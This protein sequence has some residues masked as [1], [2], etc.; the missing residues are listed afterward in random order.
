MKRLALI[1]ATL[2]LIVPAAAIE[3]CAQGKRSH[4]VVDG[5]TFWWRGE[6]IRIEAID[7]PELGQPL[8]AGERS[9]AVL[10]RDGLLSLLQQ[11]EVRISRHGP[12]RYD[13]T[14]ATVSVGGKDVGHELIA[15]G[16]AQPWLGRKATWCP[17]P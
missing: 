15:M 13:R 17:A 5:D 7:A 4:C 6:K 11:G 9:L 1:A 10:A 8:C 2:F 16:L 14:L 12:D 3:L